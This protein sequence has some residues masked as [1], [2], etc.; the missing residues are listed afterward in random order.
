MGRAFYTDSLWEGR[1]G[2]PQPRDRRIEAR[3]PF[4]AAAGNTAPALGP[5]TA[6][7]FHSLCERV[8]S[9]SRSGRAVK[10]FELRDSLAPVCLN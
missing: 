5:G 2:C 6:G 9:E 1:A 7:K 4:P 3:G 10:F 8:G